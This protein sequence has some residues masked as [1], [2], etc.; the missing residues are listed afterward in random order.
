[1]PVDLLWQ[2]G[3]LL[4]RA[5]RLK[6]SLALRGWRGTFD[7]LLGRVAFS[8][9]AS[10]PRPR[11]EE[12]PGGD[13]RCRMLVVEG[14]VPDPGRD[15][16]SLRLQALLRLLAEEGW[17][18]DLF[19]DEGQASDEDMRRLAAVGV[20]LHA[21]NAARWLRQNGRALDAAMVCRAPIALQYSPLIRKYAPQAKLIFDTVDLHFLREQ[22]AAETLGHA[23][24]RR[25]VGASRRTELRLI[26]ESDLSLVVSPVERQLLAAEL[27][28]ARIEVLSNIHEIH[29]RSE[30][31]GA[32]R[33]LL[34]V[35]GFAHPPN[36]DAIQW[37]AQ[38]ILPLLLA[39]EPTM[40]LHV[41]GEVSR[42]ARA[43]LSQEGLLF[44]GRVEDLSPL[45]NACRVSIAP[46]RFG[47]G[48]KGKVNMAMSYGVPVV[49]TSIATEGM[50]LTHGT[51]VLV[52][53]DPRAFADAVLRVYRDPGLWDRMSR[54]GLSNVATHFSMDVA[55][56]TVRKLL[57][58]TTA[59][60][61]GCS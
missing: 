31:F 27:P 40:K 12:D 8:R 42:A 22:R 43:G 6:A 23:S 20:R 51:D 3:R 48:V 52:A 9:P 56:R 50:H 55:R 33:D 60:G 26:A 53:D 16:G 49:A 30:D 7:H 46:L 2:L 44:H 29:G 34:F 10:G 14:S 57:P 54:A 15:S 5:R 4:H 39:E 58:A 37:F 17:R 1:M 41:A 38:A 13:R 11:F 59:A 61:D 28:Q 35:G 24:L 36:L 45:M 19:C 21:G 18:V 47:A 32:R 25:R